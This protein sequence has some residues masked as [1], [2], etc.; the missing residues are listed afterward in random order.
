MKLGVH[1]ALWMRTWSDD[2][3][4]LVREAG[5][6][7]YDAVELSLLG[8]D[9]AERRRVRDV[10]RSVGVELTCTTGL[11]P[12]TDVGSPDPDVRAAG[13]A[14]LADAVRATSQF[15]A[16]RLS[17][18]VYGAWGH[19]DPGR[20]DERWAHA[21]EALAEV[22]PLAA[23]EGVVLGVEAINRYETDLVN[24]AEQALNMVDAVDAPN[25]GV[26]MD[27]YHMNI[28][29]KDPAAAIRRCGSR[30]VHVHVAGRDRGVPDAGDLERHGLRD[31]LRDIGYEGCVTCEMFVQAGVP[32]SPD[33]TV[34]RAIEPDPADA[35]R[36][37]LHVLRDWAK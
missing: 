2:V 26:L 33:L 14:A 31:A 15:G 5:A 1:A 12:A 11:G 7:G 27:A 6:L 23:D 8:G 32:V 37:A 19:T 29:E 4:P 21:V 28:E 24:T 17:G 10:A 13:R 22:A 16:A 18:V 34:W 36:R 20:R 9:P 3:A 30:L 25:V 35:A